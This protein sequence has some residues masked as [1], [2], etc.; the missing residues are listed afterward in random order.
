MGWVGTLHTLGVRRGGGGKAGQ[1]HVY[2]PPP[3]YDPKTSLGFTRSHLKSL[4]D[5]WSV[6]EILIYLVFAVAVAP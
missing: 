6:P 2:V 1:L 5:T 3:I 4:G